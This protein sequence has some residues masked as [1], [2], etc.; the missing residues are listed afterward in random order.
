MVFEC[1]DLKQKS[2]NELF[3]LQFECWGE[4]IVCC[5][6]PVLPGPEADGLG[7]GWAALAD[8]SPI[9][10]GVLAVPFRPLT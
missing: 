1:L 5:Q 10:L 2:A 9:C 3:I 7:G 8:F 4:R 6:P